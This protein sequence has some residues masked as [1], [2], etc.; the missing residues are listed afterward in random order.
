MILDGVSLAEWKETC[1]VFCTVDR[2]SRGVTS[3]SQRNRIS[4]FSIVIRSQTA[5]SLLVGVHIS[6]SFSH[7]ICCPG[8]PDLCI[9]CTL[10]FQYHRISTY[11]ASK[12]VLQTGCPTFHIPRNRIS[13]PH[14]TKSLLLELCEGRTVTS[15]NNISNIGCI[16]TPPN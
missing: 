16:L 1:N 9:I 6:D 13:V 2:T 14:P 15:G 3:G 5:V 10:K 12:K 7:S 8:E 4:L 11:G